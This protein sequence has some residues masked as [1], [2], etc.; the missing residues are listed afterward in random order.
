MFILHF[1]DTLV[2]SDLAKL[3]NLSIYFFLRNI[4]NTIAICRRSYQLLLL[5]LVVVVLNA[6]L[7]LNIYN[8]AV[9]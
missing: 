4:L 6:A 9:S 3:I 7:L 1:V 2:L 8:A 5:L